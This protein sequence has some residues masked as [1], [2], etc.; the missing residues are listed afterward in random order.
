MGKCFVQFCYMKGV[1]NCMEYFIDYTAIGKNI[2]KARRAKGWTQARLAT[3]VDC[4]TP[5]MTNI[6]NANT[7]LSLAMLVSVAQALEVSTDE[8]I[9]LPSNPK[10]DKEPSAESQLREI[11][12]ALSYSDAKLCQQACVDFCKVFARHFPPATK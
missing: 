4:T 12:S 10:S 1:I 5:H 2:R 8:L 9:G 3:A 7:K 6:E 11:W